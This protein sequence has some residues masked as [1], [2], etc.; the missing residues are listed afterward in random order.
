[1]TF[2]LTTKY[3]KCYNLGKIYIG[4]ALCPALPLDDVGSL[5][6]YLSRRIPLATVY[7]KQ[8][9]IQL[10]APCSAAACAEIV[11]YKRQLLSAQWNVLKDYEMGL[12]GAQQQK[13][14]M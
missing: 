11:C 14:A 4:G 12:V 6:T 10:K 13:S 1:M 2:G 5:G 7:W 8:L 3:P 9:N